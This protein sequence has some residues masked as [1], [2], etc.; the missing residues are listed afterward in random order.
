MYKEATS[1]P[2][3]S[4]VKELRHRQVLLNAGPLNLERLDSC[5]G[6]GPGGGIRDFLTPLKSRATSGYMC[7]LAG[8]SLFQ[9]LEEGQNLGKLQNCFSLKEA[10]H[11]QTW[12]N[13]RVT[14]GWTIP[15]IVATNLN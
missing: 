8:L 3:Q 12:W 15:V 11:I 13:E 14:T 6:A 2:S 10:V 7:F 1:L 5:K 9:I 4:T